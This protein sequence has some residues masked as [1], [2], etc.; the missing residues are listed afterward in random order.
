MK[1]SAA[2]GSLVMNSLVSASSVDLTDRLEESDDGFCCGDVKCYPL[3]P[4]MTCKHAGIH[5]WIFEV[6]HFLS[7]RINQQNGPGRL[8]RNNHYI[9]SS[10]SLFS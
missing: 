3:S 1:F 5:A 6:R 4:L 9:R 7:I 2:F 10:T 8:P